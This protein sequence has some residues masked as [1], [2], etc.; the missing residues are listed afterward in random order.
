MRTKTHFTRIQ[1]SQAQNKTGKLSKGIEN[2]MC[3]MMTYFRE[4]D[5]S[6]VKKNYRTTLVGQWENF[7]C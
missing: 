5:V 6:E 2:T 7:K 3:K 1:E 4:D